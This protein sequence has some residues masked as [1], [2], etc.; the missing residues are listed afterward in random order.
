MI[1]TL[2]AV[3]FIATISLCAAQ[4]QIPNNGFEEWEIDTLPPI[5]PAAPANWTTSNFLTN[6]GANPTVFMTEDAAIGE[7]AIKVVTDTSVIPPPFG[8]GLLDTISGFVALGIVNQLAPGGFPYDERPDSVSVWIKGTVMPGDTNIL[9]INLTRLNSSTQTV[10]AVGDIRFAMLTSLP[11]Y[12][13]IT[14]PFL[15]ASNEYPDSIKVRISAGGNRASFSITPGN[16]FY[17]DEI[18]LIGQVSA[19]HQID[20][21]KQTVKILPNPMETQTILNFENPENDVFHFALM[22]SKGQVVRKIQNISGTQLL[23]QRENLPTGIYYFT[24]SN[25]GQM[26]YTGRLA[27]SK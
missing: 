26:I 15:Y 1:R 10:E 4:I 5:G 27:I 23:L 9:L 22:N 16:E 8:N 6:A 12:Q 13:K 11:E 18:Q 2:L 7:L 14:L 19:T 3:F 25:Q 21:P 24:F 20:A 17:I